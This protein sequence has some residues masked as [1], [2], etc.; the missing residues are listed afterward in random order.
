M[1]IRAKSYLKIGILLIFLIPVLIYTSN[2][3]IINSTKNQIYNSVNNIPHKKVGLL[4][5][6]SKYTTGNR[7]NL[8][9]QYRINSAAKLFHANKIDFIIVSGDNSKKGYN[10]PEQMKASLVE[11]GIPAHKIQEDFAGFRTLDSILR[12][13]IV[14]EQTSYTIISQPFHNERALFIAN[15]HNHN[16]I[17]FNARQVNHRYGLKTQLRE[18]LARVK[19]VLDLYILNKEA[20]FYGKTIKLPL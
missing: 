14:F 2:C 12:A 4:L 16:S 8:Y 18:Y 5:G 9:Y 3:W 6:T 13:E 19:A 10:E 7:I 1:K 11:Q 15:Y 20:K 17:A